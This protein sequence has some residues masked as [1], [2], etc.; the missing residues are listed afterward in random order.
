MMVLKR[1][2][3][4]AWLLLSIGF[5]LPWGWW[6]RILMCIMF[7]P[8]AAAQLTRIAPVIVGRSADGRTRYELVGAPAASTGHPGRPFRLP[9][10]HKRP[11]AV[12]HHHAGAP[13][14]RQGKTQRIKPT[15]QCLYL[16]DLD[17]STSLPIRC[18]RL[19][20]FIVVALTQTVSG[21]DTKGLGMSV[22]MQPTPLSDQVIEH[23]NRFR[24][25]TYLTYILTEVSQFD[26]LMRSTS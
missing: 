24:W 14:K 21:L 22:S 8:T 19:T 2:M 20:Y 11:V 25:W 23:L 1:N 7:A 6:I 12:G 9:G 17:H 16:V 13:T 4:M 26:S 3:I 5:V 10:G 15:L 18:R